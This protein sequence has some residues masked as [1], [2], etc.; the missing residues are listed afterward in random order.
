MTIELLRYSKD[1]GGI[2]FESEITSEGSGAD[3]KLYV[4]GIFM[5]QES[6]NRNKRIYPEKVVVPQVEAFVENY[7]KKNRAVGEL[8][9]PSTFT[10]NPDRVAHRIVEIEKVGNDYHGRALILNTPMGNIIRG[11][12]EGGVQGGMSSRGRGTTKK[13]AN[14]ISEVQG[15]YKLSTIDYVL[16]PSGIDCWV[17]P[18]LE[19]E[20]IESALLSDANLASEFEQ[21][22]AA[23]QRIRESKAAVR[24]PMTL[25]LVEQILAKF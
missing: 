23:K 11:L 15:D 6:T 7:V 1:E 22:L 2:L 20:I 8:E 3:K 9:H 24:A 10:V 4:S 19:G 25:A 21:F 14:G 16:N 17:D 18:I 12:V 5:Q 13:L